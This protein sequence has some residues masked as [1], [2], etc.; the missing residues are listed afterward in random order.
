[1]E[2]IIN[3]NK[4]QDYI[5][6]KIQNVDTPKAS[7]ADSSLLHKET[8]KISVNNLLAVTARSGDINFR[9]SSR[10][11]AVEGIRGH[12]KLQKSRSGNYQAEVTV[13]GQYQ[14]KE[15]S[16]E[17]SGRMDGVFVESDVVIVDEI[18][19]LRIDVDELPVSVQNMHWC[20]VKVYG[21]LYAAEKNLANIDLQLSYFD[22]D[23]NDVRE[24]RQHFD[25]EEL[26][27]FFE[28]IA[29]RYLRW[30]EKIQLWRKERNA[31]INDLVFPYGDFREGQRTF[32]VNA[33][34]A[35]VAGQSLFLQAP[36]GIGKTVGSLF[37][38]IK[39][40]GLGYHEKM[41]FL[42]A[43]TV[44]RS[45]AE[46]SLSD[47]SAA[48]M[49]LK[50]VTLTAK[51]KICFNPGSPCDPEHCEFAV[52]Y[53]DKLDSVLENALVERDA[54]SRKEIEIIAREQQMCPFELSLDLSSW[55]D[56]IICD[57]NYVFDPTV[58]LRRFFDDP[59]EDF[60]FLIDE[61]H[62][63]VDRGRDMFSAE[64]EK[65]RFLTLKRK[66]G[67][68]KEPG[69]IAVVRALESVNRAFLKLQ[70][71]HLQSLE[72][73]QHA[74]DIELPSTLLVSLRSFC[75]ITQTWLAEN[76]RSNGNY[77]GLL[78]LYFDAL[79]VGRTAEFFD[80]RF[81]CLIKRSGKNNFSVKL[82]CVDPSQLLEK[83]LERGRSSVFFSATLSPIEYY[84]SLLGDNSDSRFIDLPSP[85][86]TENLGLFVIR[87][88]AT[89]YHQRSGSYHRIVDVIN[90]MITSHSGNYLVYFPSY[91]YMEKVQQY[92]IEAHPFIETIGQ[93]KGM[94][95]EERHDF[96][97]RFGL[98]N[99]EVLVGFAVMG[100]IFGEGIDL[101]GR[102]LEGVVIVG[103]GLPQMGIERD[104]VKDHFGGDG[105]QKG[106][107]YAYQYPGM[108]RVL[109]TAG[110]VIRGEN[111]RGIICLVDDRFAQQRYKRLFPPHW[112]TLQVIQQAMLDSKLSE[113]WENG[114][115][116]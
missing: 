25:T 39:A 38:A 60:C 4:S 106:F 54:F 33:Y 51:D 19:T 78:D 21:W 12:Q 50:S 96:I 98:S 3:Q 107:E 8:F 102:R 27:F 89:N 64:I 17:V 59:V 69:S 13:Q 82:Y 68:G 24:F 7:A 43:K 41:F 16:L 28:N 65:Q 47:L 73:N 115:H 52:G 49:K 72:K 9:F 79:R 22:L 11:S 113:F 5:S 77:V 34:R 46:A 114:T 109:Q 40:M 74:V 111:D 26:K 42:T 32:S 15:L 84:K 94:N 99:K 1:M 53:F 85:F 110:R 20:Q 75:E 81:V 45:V 88:I 2:K 63:L 6:T 62:N 14:W 76:P 101:K 30:M 55:A 23:T 29:S 44:G 56:C 35:M 36:T 10:S 108:N 31:H 103:V 80:N 93:T 105:G 58:Y 100:G 83:A 104:I 57:Y 97:G 116:V 86:P 48:G 112:S 87:D 95:E 66:I 67:K 37:P 71:V 61:A 91:L 92:F 90:S 70:K 18:K